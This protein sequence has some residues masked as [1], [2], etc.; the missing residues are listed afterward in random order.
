MGER[1]WPG[2]IL[3]DP[4]APWELA[5]SEGRRIKPAKGTQEDREQPGRTLEGRGGHT[6][7]EGDSESL[8]PRDSHKQKRGLQQALAYHSWEVLGVGKVVSG[9]DS[10]PVPGAWLTSQSVPLTGGFCLL[11]GL[12]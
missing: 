4:W 11:P 12:F 9:S 5:R 1:G 8:F 7:V 6:R 2:V 10:S 3:G